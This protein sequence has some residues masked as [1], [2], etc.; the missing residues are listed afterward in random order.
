M[1]TQ[2]SIRSYIT[3]LA[4]QLGIRYQATPEDALAVIAARLAG[5]GVV[6]DETEDLIVAL[7]RAG[8]INGREMVALL[9]RHLDEK[10]PAQ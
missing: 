2:P 10:F 8:A 3:D 9:G 6:T 4:D 1:N 5:D 7:K